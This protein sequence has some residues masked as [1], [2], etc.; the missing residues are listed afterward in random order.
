VEGEFRLLDT[1]HRVVLPANK[2]IRSLIT[3]ADVLHC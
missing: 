3:A 1:D 2:N